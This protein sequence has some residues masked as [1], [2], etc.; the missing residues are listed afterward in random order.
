MKFSESCDASLAKPAFNFTANP[1]YD[2][3][4][5]NFDGIFATAGWE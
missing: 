1:D 2:P 5:G 3:H 4:P